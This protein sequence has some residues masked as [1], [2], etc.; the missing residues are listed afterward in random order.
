MTKVHSCK[1]AGSIP[2]FEPR[3]SAIDCSRSFNR[4]LGIYCYFCVTL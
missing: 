3:Q 1:L 4:N 2:R